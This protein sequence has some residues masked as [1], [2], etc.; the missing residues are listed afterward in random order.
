MYIYIYGEKTVPPKKLSYD[1]ISSYCWWFRNRASWGKGSL[2]HKS[3]KVFIHPNG[4]WPWEFLKHQRRMSCFSPF[5]PYQKNIRR[6]SEG[7]EWTSQN[8]PKWSSPLTGKKIKLTVTPKFCES[9]PEKKDASKKP[10]L[11]FWGVS[12]IFCRGE[13]CLNFQKIT[14]HLIEGMMI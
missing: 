8:D 9:A 6:A 3:T 10:I 13:R 12:V 7:M 1:L 11:S 14:T 2:S 5:F 4:G